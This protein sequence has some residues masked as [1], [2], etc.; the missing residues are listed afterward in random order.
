MRVYSTP[1]FTLWIILRSTWVD[2]VTAMSVGQWLFVVSLCVAFASISFNLEALCL[3]CLFYFFFIEEIAHMYMFAQSSFNGSLHS[4]S[5]FQVEY[6]RPTDRRRVR[7]LQHGFS[8][9]SFSLFNVAL[10][11]VVVGGSFFSTWALLVEMPP[12][13]DCLADWRTRPTDQRQKTLCTVQHWCCS[14]S[15]F[16][17]CSLDLKW[18]SQEAR[19]THAMTDRQHFPPF[20]PSL[21]LTLSLC[22]FFA[23]KIK[24]CCRECAGLGW[25]LACTSDDVTWLISLFVLDQWWLNYVT[26]RSCAKDK[27]HELRYQSSPRRRQKGDEKK[28]EMGKVVK[29]ELCC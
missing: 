15:S 13:S 1:L 25:C 29:S 8:P 26:C 7:Y 22:L 17:Y 28:K 6:A 11:L 16:G 27:H 3:L 9:S 5:N 12:W 19:P 2:V 20:S 23:P 14:T 10:A 18:V 21:S 24:C 4:R